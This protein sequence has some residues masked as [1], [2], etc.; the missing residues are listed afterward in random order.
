MLEWLQSKW[1]E[2]TFIAT[3]VLVV[4]SFMGIK[5][6][7]EQAKQK[8]EQFEETFTE[9]KE[10]SK[11]L[12]DPTL[13]LRNW[14]I[15]HNV[16]STVAKRWSF[17]PKGPER[18]KDGKPLEGIIYLNSNVLPEVGIR[19]KYQDSVEVVIDTIWKFTKR[20]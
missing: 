8:A 2:I 15:N 10:L 19:M 13:W 11:D 16:D 17:Y 5:A 20:E 1:K 18:G 3:V 6:D 14:L 12:K 7:A 9:I 4:W